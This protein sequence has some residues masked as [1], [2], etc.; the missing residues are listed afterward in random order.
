M[1]WCEVRPVVKAAG[2]AKLGISANTMMQ[3][4]DHFSMALF[5]APLPGGQVVVVLQI[6]RPT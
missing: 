3:D 2:A 4:V 1:R 6:Q 5:K